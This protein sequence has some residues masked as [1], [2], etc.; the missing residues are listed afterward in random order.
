[1]TKIKITGFDQNG[2]EVIYTLELPKKP[3]L[4][5]GRWIRRRKA[6]KQIKRPSCIM[7]YNDGEKIT[8]YKAPLKPWY[9]WAHNRITEGRRR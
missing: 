8:E 4:A 3:K 2:K 7:V 6:N 5:I 9:V 1:M